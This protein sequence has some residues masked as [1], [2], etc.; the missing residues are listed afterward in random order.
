MNDFTAIFSVNP[1]S[2]TVRELCFVLSTDEEINTHNNE[3]AC[4]I[5]G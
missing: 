2:S 4:H 3:I 5:Y 1:Y